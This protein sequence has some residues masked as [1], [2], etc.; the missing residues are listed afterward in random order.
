MQVL[1]S[2]M[3]ANAMFYQTDDSSSSGNQVRAG[4]LVFSL[5]QLWIGFVSCLVV[6][7][8]NVFIMYIFRNVRPR[9][10]Q[11]DEDSKSDNAD[12][13]V[14]SEENESDVLS[15]PTEKLFSCSKVGYI[16]LSLFI[17]KTVVTEF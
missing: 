13:Y 4:P 17:G 8:V 12:K 1:L 2:T 9:E 10:G 14:V 16:R 11:N 15:D 3:L 6:L 7:P 5:K